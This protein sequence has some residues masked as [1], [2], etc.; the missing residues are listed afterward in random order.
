MVDHDD[1]F[2]DFEARAAPS[3]FAG[4]DFVTGKDIPPWL[5][6]ALVMSELKEGDVYV[7]RVRDEAGDVFVIDD[8]DSGDTWL[9]GTGDPD[10]ESRWE[11]WSASL[12]EVAEAVRTHKTIIND[13]LWRALFAA[14][15]LVTSAGS[16]TMHSASYE[17][18]VEEGDC[19]LTEEEWSAVYA[20][21]LKA[22]G[23]ILGEWRKA[24]ALLVK[25]G[26][27]K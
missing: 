3:S 6:R 13:P 18:D 1:G 7:A 9:A 23:A 15:L 12:G 21:D 20:G 24:R 5:G 14:R 10:W 16:G 8:E 2:S 22:F 17:E 19:P 4:V 27:M 26:R 25:L 11:Y